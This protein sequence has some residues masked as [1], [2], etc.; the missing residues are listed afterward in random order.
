M[1]ALLLVVAGAAA[2]ALFTGAYTPP[3]SK[4]TFSIEAIRAD[5]LA[6]ERATLYRVH[7]VPLHGSKV[8][9]VTETWTLT[10]KLVD[11]AGAADPGEPGSAA[12]VDLGCTNDSVGLPGH[13]QKSVDRTDHYTSFTWHHPDAVDSVPAGKYHCNHAEMGPHG[14][15]GL[16]RLTV[17]DKRWTCTATYKGTNTSTPASATDGT[18]SKPVCRKLF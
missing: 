14:H 15:Q 9:E 12:A 1:R 17:S 11:P 18:A 6:R 13:E 7:W 3:N 4:Q 16:I 8:P 10:L 2:L 5:F